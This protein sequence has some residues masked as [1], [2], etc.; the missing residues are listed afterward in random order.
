MN[1]IGYGQGSPDLISKKAHET[2]QSKLSSGKY[3]PFLI[4]LYC[5]QW[6]IIASQNLR[7]LPP[8]TRF[9]AYCELGI[10]INDSSYI[11][12]SK[13]NQIGQETDRTNFGKLGALYSSRLRRGPNDLCPQIR[14]E[15]QGTDE[16]TANR[17][18]C[19]QSANVQ[20]VFRNEYNHIDNSLPFIKNQ[21]TRCKERMKKPQIGNRDD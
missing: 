18:F 12:S 1:A 11:D 8:L 20:V 3:S 16:M 10:K 17:H 2:F 4:I 21:K 15:I 19:T 6:L 13:A 5:L 7:T 9:L 14:A